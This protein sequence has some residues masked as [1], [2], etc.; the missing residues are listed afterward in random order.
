MTSI[1]R[2]YFSLYLYAQI[3]IAIAPNDLVFAMSA[4][5]LVVATAG[6]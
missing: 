3:I 6:P 5:H 4:L 2:K 1:F